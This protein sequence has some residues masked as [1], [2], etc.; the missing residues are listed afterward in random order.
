MRKDYSTED[1]TIFEHNA[2][3]LAK[4]KDITAALDDCEELINALQK[5]KVVTVEKQ[6]Q[7]RRLIDVM[8]EQGDKRIEGGD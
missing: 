3:L 5:L 2:G 8:E 6:E 1:I 4:L 7:S